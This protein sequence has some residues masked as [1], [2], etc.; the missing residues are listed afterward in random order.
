MNTSLPQKKDK[1]IPYYFFLFFAV[2]AL[3]D[4]GMVWM[5]IHT[6]TGLVTDHAYEKGLNYNQVVEAASAQEKLGWK[7]EIDIQPST[8]QKIQFSFKLLDNKDQRL[9]LDK[10]KLDIT[11]PTQQGMDFQ[12]DI[13]NKMEQEITFPAKGVWELRIHAMHE[14][15]EF[16]QSK[17]IVVE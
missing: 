9:K 6:Q 11:R 7:S 5:A 16:Q 8:K 10:L 4:G 17:R 13:A 14:N 12:L 15:I 1:W 3:V 2:I